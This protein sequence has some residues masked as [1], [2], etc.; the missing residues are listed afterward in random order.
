[1]E[2]GWCGYDWNCWASWFWSP[3]TAAWTQALLTGIAILVSGWL[4]RR[5]FRN[6]VD[7]ERQKIHMAE[8]QVLGR[9]DV[10]LGSASVHLHKFL[11]DARSNDGKVPRPYFRV[12]ASDLE[13]QEVA[14]RAIMMET[15][16]SVH[17]FRD[18]VAAAD[19]IRSVAVLLNEVADGVAHPRLDLPIEV[20]EDINAYAPRLL[21]YRKALGKNRD[22]TW[23]SVHPGH[24][25]FAHERQAQDTL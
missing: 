6:S 18:M 14:I 20:R 3:A 25:G 4:G 2:W 8:L 1:M 16:P 17:I 10:L 23:E 7:L 21:A 19:A 15:V 24:T 11:D 12:V 22:A 5:A 13:K 9:F